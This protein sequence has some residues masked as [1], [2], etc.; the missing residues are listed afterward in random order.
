MW[1]DTFSNSFRSFFGDRVT[2]EEAVNKWDRLSQVA[3][4]DN[5]L[6][7]IVQLTLKTGYAGEVVDAKILQNLN[8]DV[9][10]DWTKLPVKPPTLHERIQ[11]LH[12]MGHVLARHKKITTS[13]P[14]IENRGGEKK[15]AKWKGQSATADT[16]QTPAGDSTSPE[17]KENAVELKCRSEYNLALWGT[18]ADPTALLA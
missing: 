9:T 8:P 3:G 14:E 15:R 11:L 10:V 12:Q 16:A 13:G 6:D 1:W 17:K 7:Q 4:I 18:D 5:L 2:R